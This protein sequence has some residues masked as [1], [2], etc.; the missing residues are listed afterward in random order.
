MP[1][2]LSRLRS[3]TEFRA[4]SSVSQVPPLP[5]ICADFLPGGTC[6]KVR[7]VVVS[8]PDS[9]GNYGGPNSCRLQM[10]SA[11]RN[12]FYRHEPPGA[13]SRLSTSTCIGCSMARSLSTLRIGTMWE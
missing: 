13:L 8:Y 4:P 12:S 9:E 11:Q 3:L 6:D 5:S 7:T 2:E 10:M 1:G